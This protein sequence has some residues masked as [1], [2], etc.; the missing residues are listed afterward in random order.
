MFPNALY[1][2]SAFE[3]RLRSYKYCTNFEAC[4]ERGRI[5][6]TVLH[7]TGSGTN[8]WSYLYCVT[9]C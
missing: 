3:I 6:N 8:L 9:P 5:A 1:R 4:G 2:Y 7:N